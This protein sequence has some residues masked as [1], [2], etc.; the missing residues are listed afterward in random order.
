LIVID[1]QK[2]IHKE[3]EN[4]Q[5]VQPKVPITFRACNSLLLTEEG[6][7]VVFKGLRSK[8]IAL[9]LLMRGSEHGFTKE[10]F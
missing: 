9:E 7:Q 10:Q 4:G 8:A 5:K 2:I 3:E 1:P 6:H